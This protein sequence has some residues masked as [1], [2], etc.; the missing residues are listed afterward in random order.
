MVRHTHPRNN[1]KRCIALLFVSARSMS[2]TNSRQLPINRLSRAGFKRQMC[3]LIPVSNIDARART[4]V[5]DVRA[6]ELAIL[7]VEGDLKSAASLQAR[8]FARRPLWRQ[9]GEK[10]NSG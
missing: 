8:D 1:P 3:R 5:L 6:G 2:W 10:L 9:R 4:G 7:P